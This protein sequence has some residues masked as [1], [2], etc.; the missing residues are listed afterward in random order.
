LPDV[1]VLPAAL[2]IRSEG[3]WFAVANPRSGTV[4]AT[5]AGPCLG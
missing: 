3:C 4:R 2:V 1:L 5:S